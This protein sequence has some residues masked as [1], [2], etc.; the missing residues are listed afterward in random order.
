MSEEEGGAG[1][2]EGEGDREEVQGD[3]RL[4]V[5]YGL[6]RGEGSQG[7]VRIRDLFLTAL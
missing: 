2:E 3:E 6:G 4:L 7:L 5:Q 1:E